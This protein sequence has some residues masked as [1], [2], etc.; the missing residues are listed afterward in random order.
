[1]AGGT[2]W[3]PLTLS[4]TTTTHVGTALVQTGYEALPTG[5]FV[6]KVVLEDGKPYLL[7]LG[8]AAYNDDHRQEETLV[9]PN[10]LRAMGH[11][12]DDTPTCFGG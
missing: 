4:T 7:G 5:D 2:G 12:V 3:Q 11:M 6:T 9:N 1:M 10:E 8:G